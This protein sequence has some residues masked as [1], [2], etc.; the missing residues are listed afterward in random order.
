MNGHGMMFFGKGA[1]GTACRGPKAATT[2]AMRAHVG[3]VRVPP[4]AG[5]CDSRRTSAHAK[6]ARSGRFGGGGGGLGRRRVTCAAADYYQTLG[7]KRGASKEDI[8]TAYRKLARKYHPDVSKA[9]D[10]EEKFKSI[11]NAYEVLSDDE[12]RGI[13]DRYNEAELKGSPFGSAAWGPSD[14]IWTQPSGVA[15]AP[16]EFAFADGTTMAC[17]VTAEQRNALEALRSEHT[18]A[19]ELGDVTTAQQCESDFLAYLAIANR[20]NI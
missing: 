17:F 12:K 20:N 9:A 2:T 7:V 1:A 13:Y 14:D 8:K 19:L 16:F 15:D 10:A 6:G 4:C 3:G 18:E 5:C 11:S